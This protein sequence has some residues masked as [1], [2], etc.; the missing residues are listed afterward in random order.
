[1]YTL[2]GWLWSKHILNFVIENLKHLDI[3]GLYFTFY[4]ENT[5]LKSEYIVSGV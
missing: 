5:K 1:M 4:I 3:F 2:N